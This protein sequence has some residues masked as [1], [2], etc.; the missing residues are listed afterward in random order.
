MQPVT[1]QYY[2][3]VLCV[4][5]YINQVRID[6]AER[7]FAAALRVELRFCSVFGDVPGKLERGWATRGGA[8]GYGRH[9]RKVAAEYAHVQVHPDTWGRVAPR[10]SMP[11]HLAVCALRQ[12]EA[13]GELAPHSGAKLCWA[14][15]KAFF[16]EA[17]DVSRRD[18]L[19]ELL[20]AHGV[21]RGPV[22]ASLDDGTAHAL[23]S[24][25]LELAASHD[26]KMSPSLVLNEGRQRLS[27][28]VGFRV[29]EANLRELLQ[30]HDSGDAS[31]C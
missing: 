3:D 21:A 8:E 5:A 15:R 13:R 25:D 23:L 1:A 27:G 9:V 26:V 12:L 4:W 16:A 2:T 10:S 14:L 19:L 29:I 6:E 11:C 18:V 30:S 20:E 28:N 22:E 24:K 31:W 7:S 17:R